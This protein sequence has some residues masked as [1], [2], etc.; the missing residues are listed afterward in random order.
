M[1]NV[2]IYDMK[3]VDFT[4]V[5]D[6]DIKV[7]FEDGYKQV[8]P[9]IL[10]H[11]YTTGYG[12]QMGG[13]ACLITNTHPSESIR[14]VYLDVVPYYVRI[15]LHA[16]KIKI[17]ELDIKPEKLQFVPAYNRERPASIEFIITI[18]AKSTAKVTIEFE[19]VFLDW[20]QYKPDANHGFY[21]GSSVVST[22]IPVLNDTVLRTN[23]CSSLA[24]ADLCKRGVDSVGG[25]F[26]R[27]FSEPLLIRVP[28]PDFSMPYNVLCLACTVIAIGFGSIYNLSTK[29]LQIEDEGKKKPLK[30]KLNIAKEFIKYSI[31]KLKGRFSGGEETDS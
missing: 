7:D 14:I 18:P 26:R 12:F 25:V 15:Y 11:K 31:V 30:E 16:L 5:F 8:S 22:Y 23:Q 27:I 3:K 19:K 29:T 28:L 6:I 10:L 9:Y 4:S 20:M 17:N 21:L 2:N 24:D 1:D 13:I